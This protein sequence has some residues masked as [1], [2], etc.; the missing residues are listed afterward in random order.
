[1]KYISIESAYNKHIANARKAAVGLSGMARA[2]AIYD[3]FSESTDHPHARFTY[4]QLMMNRTSDNQF[5]IDLMRE[6][7]DLCAKNAFG[8]I[9]SKHSGLW[10]SEKAI[11]N[12]GLNGCYAQKYKDRLSTRVLV[13]LE[14][15]GKDDDTSSRVFEN[16]DE[17]DAWIDAMYSASDYQRNGA[18]TASLIIKALDNSRQNYYPLEAETYQ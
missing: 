2:Q 9:H 6:M 14:V 3:Y 7:A 15:N 10:S 8:S 1:M 5:P 11:G 12:C 16:D 18:T 13:V 17:L 4:D